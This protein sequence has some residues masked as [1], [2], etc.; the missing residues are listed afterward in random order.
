MENTLEESKVR[1]GELLSELFLVPK[2]QI[3]C[4]LAIGMFQSH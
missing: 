1:D 2:M 4:F 3:V